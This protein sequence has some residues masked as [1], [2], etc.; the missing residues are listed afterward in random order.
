[1]GPELTL[2]LRIGLRCWR[3]KGTIPSDQFPERVSALMM[4]HLAAHP[5]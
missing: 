2:M 4:E 5:V 1:M 3:V